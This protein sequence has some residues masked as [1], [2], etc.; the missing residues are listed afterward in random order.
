MG[1]HILGAIPKRSFRGI[2]LSTDTRHVLKF[3]KDPFRGVDGIDFEIATFAKQIPSPYR[4]PPTM[5]FKNRS[6]LASSLFEMPKVVQ[7]TADRIQHTATA[8]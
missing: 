1:P 7:C 3:R 5:C 4:R 8:N 2:L 6:S